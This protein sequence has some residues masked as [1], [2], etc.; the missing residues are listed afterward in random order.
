MSTKRTC[1]ICGIPGGRLVARIVPYDAWGSLSRNQRP[2]PA[3][4]S[5]HREVKPARVHLMCLMGGARL[6]RA[7]LAARCPC[8]CGSTRLAVDAADLE[9]M[10]GYAIADAA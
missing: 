1:D 10:T 8:G 9:E 5:Y 7:A 4:A 6:A 2:A 3:G